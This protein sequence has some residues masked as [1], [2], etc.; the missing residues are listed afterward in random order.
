[1]SLN[2]CEQRIFDYLQGHR[3]EN[4]FWRE[5]VQAAAA[6]ATDIHAASARLEIE[7]WQYYQERSAVVPQFKEA[8]RREPLRRMS[9]RN[10]AEL[11]L[12]L[13]TEPRPKKPSPFGD[14][15]DSTGANNT[16]NRIP[17]SYL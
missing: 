7:L 1:M 13:W 4:R 10:L 5:K 3:D 8:I 6:R 14:A 2:V 15:G 9:M 16:P 12:R 11:L 17:P